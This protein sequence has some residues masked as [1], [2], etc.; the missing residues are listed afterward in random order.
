MIDDFS[1][2]C[3]LTVLSVADTLF[4]I[5][6]I[7]HVTESSGLPAEDGMITSFHVVSN[8]LVLAWTSFL[9]A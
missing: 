8:R 2:L 7:T 5:L 9:M 6:E 1:W 4:H 3:G